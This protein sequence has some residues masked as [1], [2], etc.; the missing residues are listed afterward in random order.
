[1][2]YLVLALH[3]EIC[4]Q[5]SLQRKNLYSSSR[6]NFFPETYTNITVSQG[7]PI[8]SAGQAQFPC[9]GNI[10]WASERAMLAWEHGL[11]RIP[12]CRG[13]EPAGTAEAELTE[14]PWVPSAHPAQ[15]HLRAGSWGT[16]VTSCLVAAP[17]PP[18]PTA[19]KGRL[20]NIYCH[21]HS[22]KFFLRGRE[23][24]RSVSLH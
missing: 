5:S 24:R 1:M 20:V 21:L 11:V 13:S 6:A 3:A 16:A 14:L 22:L 12:S 7:W 2:R 23:A 8:C 10:M 4:C 19:I 18:S 9:Q 15:P 17:N